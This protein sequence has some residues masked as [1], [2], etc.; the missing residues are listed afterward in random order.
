MNGKGALPLLIVLWAVSLAFM[1]STGHVLFRFLFYLFTSLIT[2]SFVW[3]WQNLHGLEVE[4]TVVS[5]K[6]QVG[7]ILEEE[8][9][10]RNRSSLPKFWLEVRDH[11]SLP[12]HVAGRVIG[13]I[14]P[15][16]EHRWSVKTLCRKR[17][18]FTLGP[19][20]VV[21][22]DPLGLVRFEKVFPT[23]L[24]VTVY[25]PVY[26]LPHFKLLS[27]VLPGGEVVRQ[28]A[29]YATTNVAGVRDY[30][31]GDSFNRI[32]WPTTAHAGRLMVKE[33]ELDPL[34]NV[35]I[36]IDLDRRVQKGEPWPRSFVESRGPSLFWAEGWALR[37]EPTTEE[38]AVAIAASL[39]AKLL[40]EKRALG[41][42]AC[43]QA[44]YILRPERGLRQLLK[45]LDFLAVVRAEGDKPFEELLASE[46]P[47]LEGNSTVIA[48]TPS[49]S[50]RWVKVIQSMKMR[51]ID[52]LAVIVAEN[53]EDYREVMA[54]LRASAIPWILVRLGDEIPAA[55]DSG[56]VRWG[57]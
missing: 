2:L 39:A 4:R 1:L 3:V 52:A 26:S 30:C 48:I 12:A 36:F 32:H 8:I 20:T 47:F 37:P 44:R 10:V 34:S 33:F 25:P 35:W 18:V 51:G 27:G 50:T 21:S 9:V 24:E 29:P 57:T 43:S 16:G 46:S 40:R 6:A 7:K 22:S 55:M 53:P 11:S 14:P 5:P 23:K 13:S 49:E 42:A 19:V 31:P 54:E 41:L 17:G 56:R 45:V 15:K 28:R 38:Y